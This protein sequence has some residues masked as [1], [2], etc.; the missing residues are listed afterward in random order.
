MAESRP[1]GFQRVVDLLGIPRDDRTEFQTWS[2]LLAPLARMEGRIA[3]RRLFDRF[4]APARVH[5]P[6][7]LSAT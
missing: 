6:Q 2:D 1:P 5:R 4:P 7:D 3:L